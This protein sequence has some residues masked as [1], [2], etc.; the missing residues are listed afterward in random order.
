MR[1][2]VILFRLI[3]RVRYNEFATLFRFYM[4]VSPTKKFDFHPYISLLIVVFI[5][6]R[7]RLTL[8]KSSCFYCEKIHFIV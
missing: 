8:C 7:L 5:Y 1:S 3:L 4:S 6:V 2:F